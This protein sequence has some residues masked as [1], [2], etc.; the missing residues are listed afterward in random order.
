MISQDKKLATNQAISPYS[1]SQ[2]M[3]IVANG[4][5]ENMKNVWLHKMG[6]H[7]DVFHFNLESKK[8]YSLLI[9]TKK[10]CVENERTA[11][12]SNERKE[13]SMHVTNIFKSITN[14]VYNATIIPFDPNN[15][16]EALEKFNK[17]VAL[18][19]DNTI[20]KAIQSLSSDI[21]VLLLNVLHLDFEWLYKYENCEYN[22]YED[23]EKIV[24]K[25]PYSNEDYSFI[26]IMPKD[27]KYW[28]DI[29]FFLSLMTLKEAKLTFPKFEYENELN[30][31]DYLPY[32]G[33]NDI[34]NDVT[35]I[36]EVD[37]TKTI[38][39]QKVFIKVNEYGTTNSTYVN[40][41]I[42]NCSYLDAQP[43]IINRPFFFYI[44][45]HDVKVNSNL[46][47]VV[48]KYLGREN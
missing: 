32:L 20:K 28:N 5:N 41:N 11:E 39:K 25:I 48:G 33:R 12:S 3:G 23:D 40:Q 38:I 35:V 19:T 8:Y 22:T 43:I 29:G 21:S 13:F 9:S 4:T 42:E 45:R 18:N 1:F 14:R 31:S 2:A 17:L 15:T 6:F 34:M 10:K 26:A 36:E 47:I 46:P 16:E 44:I 37:I 7:E 30:F 27:A 24:I